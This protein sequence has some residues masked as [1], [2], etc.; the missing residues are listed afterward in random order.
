MTTPQSKILEFGQLPYEGSQGP[1]LQETLLR[2]ISDRPYA[3][4]GRL[5]AKHQFEVLA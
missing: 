4:H 2:A 3:I 1:F 5:R